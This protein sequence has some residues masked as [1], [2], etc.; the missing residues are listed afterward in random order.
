MTAAK[1]SISPSRAALRAA[2]RASVSSRMRAISVFD[3]SRTAATS[4]SAR[5][6]R[7]AASSADAGAD[8]LDGRL[9]IGGEAGHRL[10]ARGLGRGL[11]RPAQVGHE[12]GRPARSRRWRSRRSCR[13]SRAPPRRWDRPRRRASSSAAR[14]L[15]RRVDGVGGRSRSASHRR[16]VGRLFGVA[17][18]GRPGKPEARSRVGLG[19]AVSILVVGTS[20]GVDPTSTAERIVAARVG[21]V[22]LTSGTSGRAGGTAVRSPRRTA[23]SRPHCAIAGRRPS[24]RGY[25]GP[26]WQ[27]A[28][29]FDGRPGPTDTLG[30]ADARPAHLG[31]R[32]VQLP[33]HVL[34]A[35]GGLRAGLR[36]P[37]AAT[38][39]CASRR[40]S[41]SLA[42]SSALGVEKLRITGG[43]PLVR[44]DL[45]DLIA[46]LAAIRRPDGGAL[47]LTLTTNGSALRGAGRPLGRRRPAARHG[48]PRLARRRGLRGD[49]R[50]RLPGR[51]RAR[52]DR[53]RHRGRASPRSRSTWSSGAASTRRASCRWRAGRA[54]PA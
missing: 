16:R 39:S 44:R 25:H 40:S 52:R 18:L 13:S 19:H 50:D 8:L 36:V 4:S 45:P 49:E 33:V 23:V 12:L 1:A 30:R 27:R 32:P 17:P 11:H 24:V 20:G 6:R 41:G 2:I 10:V 48:Q 31:H 42:R 5:R 14:R 37:A 9:R 38:R 29:R 26:R 34:H 47:D 28:R 46:M 51:A 53:R 3:H 21:E 7:P 54:R 35:Q 22:Q 43:E 15:G